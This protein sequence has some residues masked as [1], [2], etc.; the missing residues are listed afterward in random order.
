[1]SPEKLPDNI[2]NLKSFSQSA[3]ASIP[4][5]PTISPMQSQQLVMIPGTTIYDKYIILIFG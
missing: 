2:L 5:I 4:T 3:A 1:M